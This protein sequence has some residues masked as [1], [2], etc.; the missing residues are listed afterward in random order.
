MHLIINV[1]HITTILTLGNFELKNSVVCLHLP[2]LKLVQGSPNQSCR[3][4]QK[5]NLPVYQYI[6]LFVTCIV[7][8]K[9]AKAGKTSFRV[10]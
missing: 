4:Y 3:L 9:E 10:F 8:F 7:P 5:I 1:F 2:L 6:Y